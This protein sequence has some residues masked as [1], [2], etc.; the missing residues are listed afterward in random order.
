MPRVLLILIVALLAGPLGGAELT[1]RIEPRWQNAALVVPSG[2]LLSSEGQTVRVTRFAAIVSVI[3]FR[4]PDLH[5]NQSE[6][7]WR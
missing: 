6:P 2:P 1:L 4:H 5:W 3:R 7:T